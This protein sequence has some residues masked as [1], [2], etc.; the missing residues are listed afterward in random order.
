LTGNIP[1]NLS[2][3]TNL[4]SSMVNIGYNGLYTDDDGLRT[5]LNSKDVDWEAT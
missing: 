3:L 2:S 5:F 1:S 4:S